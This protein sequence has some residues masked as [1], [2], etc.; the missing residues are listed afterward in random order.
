M[1]C[2]ILTYEPWIWLKVTSMA[3]TASNRKS[4]KNPLKSGF[5]DDLFHIK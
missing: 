2:G 3:S 4:A 1:R 5:F